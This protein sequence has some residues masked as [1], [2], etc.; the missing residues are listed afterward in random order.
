MYIEPCSIE[1]C[2]I[3]LKMLISKFI[4]YVLIHLLN[5]GVPSSH[6]LNT[7]IVVSHFQIGTCK[8]N[9]GPPEVCK[10]LNSFNWYY[11]QFLIISRAT[12]MHDMD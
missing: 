1:P 4:D 10:V 3:E 11:C 5:L 2:S 9:K 6:L 8:V 7:L 12:S